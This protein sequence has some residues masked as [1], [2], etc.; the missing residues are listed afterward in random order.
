MVMLAGE[1]LN[2]LGT[3]ALVYILISR[4]R[5]AELLG[6]YSIVLA[7]LTVFQS[8]GCFGIPEYLL[9][10]TARVGARK[11][12]SYI[13]HSL[14][15]GAASSAVLSVVM[16]MCILLSPYG[17]ELRRALHAG[18]LTIVPAAIASIARSVVLSRGQSHLILLVSVSESLLYVSLTTYLVLSGGGILS[19]IVSVI[20]GKLLSCT[21]YLGF[22]DVRRLARGPRPA[23]GFVRHMLGPVGS[24]ALSNSLGYISLRINIIILSQW[25]VTAAVG[26]YSAAS[27]IIE[28]TLIVPGIFAQIMLPRLARGVA[29][30][31]DYVARNCEKLLAIV[32]AA[33]APVGAAIYFFAPVV[34]TTLFGPDFARSDTVLILRILTVFLVVESLDGTI[35]LCLKATGRQ[36]A[37]VRMYAFNP[38][39]NIVAS[40]C[41][42]P[43][44]GPSGAA[45]GR[46]AGVVVSAVVRQSYVSRQFL[47]LNWLR[48][49]GVPLAV[50]L[51]G[52]LGLLVL[53]DLVPLLVLAL[54]Y[55]AVMG[56]ILYPYARWI[57]QKTTA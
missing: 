26:F 35:S 48:I 54:G 55:V 50:S 1:V 24:F 37:D 12:E 18:I 16:E 8:A 30:Q 3:G 41:L 49:A 32:C 46:V 13:L 25:V 7:W 36:G 53:R 19:L 11:D 2:L 47:R 44:L 43:V 51:S 42:V 21:L 38:A 28:L 56:G 14:L 29:A 10:E 52:M 5:G 40:L 33:A 31:P 9:R 45:L 4:I 17:G 15:L 57:G 34:L 20:A 39:T 23:P 6:E 27:K 22:L